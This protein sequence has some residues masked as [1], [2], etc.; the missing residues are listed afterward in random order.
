MPTP[1]RLREHY[2]LYGPRELGTIELL[3]L[4]LGTG[5]RGISATA[6]ATGLIAHFGSLSQLRTAP[7]QALAAVPGVG[8]ARAVR[9]HAALQLSQRAK[10]RPDSSRLDHPAAL[11]AF[12]RPHLAPEPVESFWV[13]CLDSRLHAQSC[14]MLSRGSKRCTVV[15]PAEVFRSAILLRSNAIAVAHNH[16]SGDPTPS[17]E[18]HALT[19]RLV[20]CGR[21]LGIPLLDHMVI[22]ARDHWSFADQNALPTALDLRSL[23]GAAEYSGPF[24]SR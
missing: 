14:Q 3:T 17:Q 19:R 2:S 20:Q 11:A 22:G 16:P 9:V 12:I 8:P 5:A 7:V 1:P 4:V 10:V 15:D 23:T 6:M 13:V 18:D 24:R 21:L